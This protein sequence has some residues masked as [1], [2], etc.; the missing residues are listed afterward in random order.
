VLPSELASGSSI[1]RYAVPSGTVFVSS[2]TESPATARATHPQLF[3]IDDRNAPHGRPS[4]LARITAVEA[5]TQTP[6]HSPWKISP[7]L[8]QCRR[9]SP[10]FRSQVTRLAAGSSNRAAPARTC[11]LPSSSVS[12][13]SPEK[14]VVPTEAAA[15]PTCACCADTTVPNPGVDALRDRSGCQSEGQHYGGDDP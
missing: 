14:T 3:R 7:C 1:T 12:R 13:L 6:W 5:C 11:K 10:L 2:S 4:P 8:L 15:R 9:R